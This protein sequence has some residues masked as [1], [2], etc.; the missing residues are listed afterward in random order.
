MYQNFEGLERGEDIK[1]F[2]FW[3]AFPNPLCVLNQKNLFPTLIYQFEHLLHWSG[4]P[5]AT[6]TNVLQK[7]YGHKKMTFYISW[8]VYN[9]PSVQKCKKIVNHCGLSQISN[10]LERNLLERNLQS[11]RKK[12][13]IFLKEI[14]SKEIFS[15][16]IFSKDIFLRDIFCKDIFSKKSSRKKSSQE[17]SLK[18]KTSLKLVS[19]RMR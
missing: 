7:N 4:T 6:K 10:L 8:F 2:Q 17:K 19:D 18:N 13:T 3:G 15:K 11:S 9:R 16:E 1:N 14:F 12:S 5:Y